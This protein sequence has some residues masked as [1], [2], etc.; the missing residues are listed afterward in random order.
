MLVVILAMPLIEEFV[1]RAWFLTYAS[2]AIG[3]VLALA[4][5]SLAFA[6]VHAPTDTPVFIWYLASGFV[7]GILWSQTRSLL[8]CVVAHATVNALLV[9]LSQFL[10][11]SS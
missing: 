3:S 9:L 11:T 5:S 10:S 7:L 2:R 4:I 8:A 1:F 6:A